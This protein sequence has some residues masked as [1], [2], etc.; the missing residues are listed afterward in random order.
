MAN[1]Q[2]QKELWVAAVAQHKMLNALVTNLS[3]GNFVQFRWLDDSKDALERARRELL[4][5]GEVSRAELA[6]VFPEPAK[7]ENNEQV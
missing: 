6:E 3:T 7:E 5:S 2:A 1:I 4:G